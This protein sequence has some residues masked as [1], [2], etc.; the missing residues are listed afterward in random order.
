MEGTL[1]GGFLGAGWE[2]ALRQVLG[3][4]APSCGMSEDGVPQSSPGTAEGQAVCLGGASPPH[5]FH[6]VPVSG[7]PQSSANTFSRM[8]TV[9]W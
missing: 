1:A 4:R 7:A 2:G 5:P 8:G 3:G 9:L 6:F